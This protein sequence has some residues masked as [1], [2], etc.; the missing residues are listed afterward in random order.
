MLYICVLES[1][2]LKFCC[3]SGFSIVT[4]SGITLFLLTMEDIVL[5]KAFLYYYILH[6]GDVSKS[7]LLL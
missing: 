1:L 7:I 2:L 3:P 5:S 4:F 6:S